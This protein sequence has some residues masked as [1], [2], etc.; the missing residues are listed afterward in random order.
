MLLL[1]LIMCHGDLILAE[2]ITYSRIEV[3]R[4]TKHHED[5]ANNRLQPVEQRHRLNES[6]HDRDQQT[7]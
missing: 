5:I 3:R 1:G 6:G 7:G 4:A 2:Q